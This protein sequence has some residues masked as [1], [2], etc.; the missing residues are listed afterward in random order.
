MQAGEQHGRLDLR[1]GDRRRI[2]DGHQ[3]G[4]AADGERQP[5][6]AA[7]LDLEAHLRQRLEHAAHGPARQRGVADE[8]HAHVVAGDQRP[9]SGARRCRSC[10]NRCRRR[11]GR[12]RRRRGPAPPTSSP[13]LRTGQPR[14]QRL[15]GVEH[16]LALEQARDA[17]CGRW[18][19]RRASGR[20]ARSTC[21][22]ARAR[23]PTGPAGLRAERGEGEECDTGLPAAL[24]GP[25]WA[26]LGS[27]R[28]LAAA[29]LRRHRAAAPKAVNRPVNI[30]RDRRDRHG[31]AV[32]PRAPICF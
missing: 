26:Q 2:L 22:P 29:T 32:D 4:A 1:R 9:S 7:L 24:L 27:G 10:R 12:A 20:G 5:V 19:A 25:G 6:A 18:R 21:R 8:A 15:G 28:P 11:A 14:P 16:V 23:G 31:R 13:C 30:P 17:W 3:V